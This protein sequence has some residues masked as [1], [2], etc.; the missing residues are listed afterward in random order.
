LVLKLGGNDDILLNK[1]NLEELNTKGTTMLDIENGLESFKFI[2]DRT[3]LHFETK[4]TICESKNSEIHIVNDAKYP[5][6]LAI[7]TTTYNLK[8]D[9]F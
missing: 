1:Q 9:T 6:V 7:K 4:T 5:F 3:S 8:F 2:E